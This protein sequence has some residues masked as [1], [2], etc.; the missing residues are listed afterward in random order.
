MLLA[1]ASL[2]LA[3][4][5]SYGKIG[6]PLHCCFLFPV[7]LDGNQAVPSPPDCFRFEFAARISIEPVSAFAALE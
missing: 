5:L 1:A 2:A 4:C 7:G 6:T 3:P